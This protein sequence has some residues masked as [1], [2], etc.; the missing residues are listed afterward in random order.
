MGTTNPC[1]KL[2]SCHHCTAKRRRTEAVQPSSQNDKHK[3][4][5]PKG[6]LLGRIGKPLV[7]RH[8][9][10]KL[11]HIGARQP[12]KS[13]SEIAGDLQSFPVDHQA[14]GARERP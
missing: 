4:L 7:N 14:F 5:P 13:I 11:A 3:E 8:A 2:G 6:G 1:E 10:L 12:R 9:L